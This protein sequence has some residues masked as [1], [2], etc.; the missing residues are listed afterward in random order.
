MVAMLAFVEN[1]PDD[2]DPAA[3]IQHDRTPSALLHRKIAVSGPVR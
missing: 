1:L 2:G 3:R